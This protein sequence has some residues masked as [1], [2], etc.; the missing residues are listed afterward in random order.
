M[1]EKAVVYLR[2]VVLFGGKRE[3]GGGGGSSSIAGLTRKIIS[4]KLDE[5]NLGVDTFIAC[6]AL[7]SC[8][9]S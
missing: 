4:L 5:I 2:G 6:L 8:L 9:A 7:N 3:K 1:K